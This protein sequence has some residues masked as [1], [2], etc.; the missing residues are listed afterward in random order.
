MHPGWEHC[1]WNHVEARRWVA[2]MMPEWL[3]CYD[4]YP[5]DRQRE[6]MFRW[7]VLW[8]LGGV[9]LSAEMRPLESFEGMGDG[10]LVLAVEAPPPSSSPTSSGSPSQPSSTSPSGAST[11]E[12]HSPPQILTFFTKHAFN[13]IAIPSIRHEISWWPSTSRISFDFVPV[14]STCDAPRSLKIIPPPPSP[15]SAFPT[16][17]RRAPMTP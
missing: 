7:L 15:I 5:L 13:P 17:P 14:F 1:F 8:R 12:P 4:F 10:G 9:W 2:E 16:E 3:E 6:Q 11:P